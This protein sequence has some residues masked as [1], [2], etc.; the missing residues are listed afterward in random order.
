MHDGA[1]PVVFIV[2][3]DPSVQRALSRFLRTQGFSPRIFSSAAEFLDAEISRDVAGCLLLDV[4]MPGMS[5]ME[6]HAEIQRQGL[7]LGIVFITGHGNIPMSVEAMKQGAVDFLEKPFESRTIMDVVQKAIERSRQRA[8]EA[9]ECL[10]LQE[11]LESLTPREREVFRWVVKGM[12]NKQIAFELGTVEKTIK[13]HRAR[14]M[15]KMQADS[16]AD[17]VRIAEKLKLPNCSL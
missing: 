4:E 10:D 3:D 11:R 7:N 17:L 6:L 12:L 8:A 2:D 5:G 14:V 13:V 1:E 16:L 15:T 9:R